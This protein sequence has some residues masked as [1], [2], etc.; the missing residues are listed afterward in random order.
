ML[1][2]QARG[3]SR[4]NDVAGKNLP[5]SASRVPPTLGGKECNGKGVE[6]PRD[7][8]KSKKF[9]KSWA[10][11]SRSGKHDMYLLKEA[12]LLLI[13]NDSPLPPEWKDH[14]LKGNTEEI[15]E[16]H[17]KGDLLLVYQVYDD[18][19]GGL[20]TFLDAGTHAEIF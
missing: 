11:L 2:V 14:A 5:L 7:S 1:F 9:L 6:L 10:R 18:E 13:A 12:M 8:R 3:Y 16:C 4:E 15:R 20:I 17:V 19:D